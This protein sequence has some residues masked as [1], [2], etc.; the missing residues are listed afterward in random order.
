MSEE[1]LIKFAIFIDK[2]ENGLITPVEFDNESK[3]GPLTKQYLILA[4]FMPTD[5]NK[6]ID[7]YFEFV[8]GRPAAWDMIKSMIEYLDIH[9]SLVLVEGVPIEGAKTV[10]E[11]MKYAEVFFPEDTF[12]IEDYNYGDVDEDDLQEINNT[13][14]SI[15]APISNLIY[16]EQQNDENN[17]I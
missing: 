16:N 6:D 2:N 11:F 14:Y 17:N 15:T 9:E 7:K 1:K 10:Y 13:E 3:K 5:E 12:D 4:V 8:T